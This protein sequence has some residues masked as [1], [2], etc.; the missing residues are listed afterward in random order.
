MCF[1]VGKGIAMDAQL[2]GQSYNHIDRPDL[3]S[4]CI[5]IQGRSARDPEILIV[6]GRP[7]APEASESAMEVVT[8][9]SAVTSGGARTAFRHRAYLYLSEDRFVLRCALRERDDGN[10][11][12]FV[13]CL[14][15]LPDKLSESWARGVMAYMERTAGDHERKIEDPAKRA[16]LKALRW[17]PFYRKLIQHGYL[18]SILMIVLPFLQNLYIRFFGYV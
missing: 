8:R 7:L 4:L 1:A 16:G 17:A 12:C 15:N 13:S 10:R 6:D 2:P 14:G 18:R 3:S 9:F 11:F 5:W